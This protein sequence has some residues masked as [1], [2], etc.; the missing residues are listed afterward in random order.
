MKNILIQKKHENP[1]K[2]FRVCLVYVLSGILEAEKTTQ[3][4]Q[5]ACTT[6]AVLTCMG[7]INPKALPQIHPLYFRSC[8][9][10]YS[11]VCSN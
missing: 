7:L 2:L 3:E 4:I 11:R 5:L 1:H 10:R 9:H 8:M 6:H